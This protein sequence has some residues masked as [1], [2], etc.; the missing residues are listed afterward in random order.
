[1]DKFNI[2]ETLGK[3]QNDVEEILG[4]ITGD[5]PFWRLALLLAVLI[6]VSK[7]TFTRGGKLYDLPWV[8]KVIACVLACHMT[9]QLAAS[10]KKA[11]EEKEKKEE[12]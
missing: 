4:G 9:V 10:K 6:Y 11:D 8:V 3:V 5:S 2:K 7:L 12:V 1:M